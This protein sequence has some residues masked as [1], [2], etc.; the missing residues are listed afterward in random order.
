MR[1]IALVPATLVMA[2]A[3]APPAGAAGVPLTI[4]GFNQDIVVEAG[5]VNDPTTH[6]ANNVTATMDDGAAKTGNTWYERG[7][8]TAAPTTGLPM[9]LVAAAQDDPTLTFRLASAVGNNALLLDTAH[10]SGNINLSVPIRLS[11]LYILAASG[12]GSVTN[13]SLGLQF[14]DLAPPITTTYNAPDWFNGTPVAVNASGRVVPSTGAFANVGESNPRLYYYTVDI[15]ALGGANREL[16][17]INFAFNGGATTHTAIMAIS[18]EPVPE[19]GAGF[20]LLAA[21]AVLGRAQRRSR[22]RQPRGA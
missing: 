7:L 13:A 22:Q 20:A 21:G 19:P 15:A 5:A 18:G 17:F 2:A 3:A 1:S 8:N 11:K 9:N 10:P 4:S 12:N 6:Y 14:F 16:S